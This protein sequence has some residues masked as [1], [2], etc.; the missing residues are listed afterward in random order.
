MIDC[1]KAEGADQESDANKGDDNANKDIDDQYEKVTTKD[2]TDLSC[3][4]IMKT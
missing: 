1:I 4:N 3:T 2:F